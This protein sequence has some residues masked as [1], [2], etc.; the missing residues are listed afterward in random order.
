[1]M[2]SA[3]LYTVILQACGVSA[4]VI[5][6][7]H[8][9]STWLKA[10][11]VLAFVVVT[12]GIILK[13]FS[14]YDAKRSLL[15]SLCAAACFVAVY[16]IVG[17]SFAPGIVKDIDPFSAQHVA[18]SCKVFLGMLVFYSLCC[19]CLIATSGRKKAQTD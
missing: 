16:Q 17:F 6:S 5:A 3:L 4:F 12:L 1:M 7:S 8:G 9:Q 11:V 2:H 13:E 14:R 19:A 10:A 18:A 15:Y